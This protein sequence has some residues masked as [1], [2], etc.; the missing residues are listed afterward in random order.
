MCICMCMYQY[1][2][3][4]MNEMCVCECVCVCVCV[5]VCMRKYQYWKESMN[6]RAS[7]ALSLGR[8]LSTCYDDSMRQHTSPYVLVIS[9]IEDL[10]ETYT[11]VC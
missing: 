6:E 5:C 1:W 9:H 11:D 7:A 8:Y 3:E 2:K 10:S 4:R